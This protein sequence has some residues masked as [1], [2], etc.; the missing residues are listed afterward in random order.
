MDKLREL[1]RLLRMGFDARTVARTF[2]MRPNTEQLNRDGVPTAG[3]L[4]GSPDDLPELNVLARAG[5]E[6]RSRP[7]QEQS[8][9]EH[10]RASPPSP[11]PPTTRS[12]PAYPPRS[13]G[14]RSDPAARPRPPRYPPA[15]RA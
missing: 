10:W 5:A 14:A 12:R 7:R 1:V 2:K 6:A 3:L 15:R 9:I 4:D 13:I 11:C 8:S